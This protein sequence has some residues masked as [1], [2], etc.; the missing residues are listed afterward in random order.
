VWVLLGG[1]IRVETPGGGFHFQNHSPAIRV[2]SA[3]IEKCA[4]CR[5]HLCPDW[6]LKSFH[7]ANR[8]AEAAGDT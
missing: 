4:F 1:G 7:C 8:N 6:N 5:T 3:S 2:S